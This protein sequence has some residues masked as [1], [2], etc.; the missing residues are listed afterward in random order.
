MENNENNNNSTLNDKLNIFSKIENYKYEILLGLIIIGSIFFYLKNKN[1]DNKIIP[2]KKK[3]NPKIPRVIYQCYKNKNIS[4]TIKNKWLELNPDFEYHHYDNEECYHFLL[5]NYGEH[6]AKFFKF[7]KHGPIKSDFWRV[8]ILYK[9]GGVYADIDIIP[10]VPIDEF[11]NN[12]TTLYTC[13]TYP[14]I[15]NNLNP[16][17]IA[18]EPNNPLILE[19]I[20]VYMKDRI[21]RPYSYYGYSITFIMLE[22]FQKYFNIYKFEEKIYKKDNQIIQLSQEICP[23]RNQ[24]SCYIQ[25]N[26]IQIMKNRDPNVYDMIK[27]EF[28]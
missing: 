2:F 23:T 20:N 24:N 22:V 25:Q 1:F 4:P 10:F 13:A 26:N 6:F 8:C 11:V 5:N 12:D 18:V 27:H 9:L 16:H 14:L 28:K 3:M 19:C 7:I 17:F 21:F 15:G